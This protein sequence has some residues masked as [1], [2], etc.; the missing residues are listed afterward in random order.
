MATR[1][2]R[3]SQAAGR[4]D[5]L[6]GRDARHRWSRYDN[7]EVQI[8]VDG[9]PPQR[10]TLLLGAMGNGCYFGGGMKICPNSSLDDG[11]LDLVVVGD[12]TKLEVAAKIGHLYA[13]THLP[14][15]QVSAVQ[16]RQV[17]VMPVEGS[18]EIPIELDGE[19]PGRLPAT[20]EVLPQRCGCGSRGAE[21]PGPLTP[22]LSPRPGRG[23][24]NRS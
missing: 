18:G 24:T 23:R 9:G 16:G 14:L 8:R 11:L 3:S 7:I 10:R 17:E 5:G 19:T 15:K 1:A 12:F 4:Q 22:T 13:G 20:F 6:P 2:N 21:M